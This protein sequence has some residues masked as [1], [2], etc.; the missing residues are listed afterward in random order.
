MGV[1]QSMMG[2]SRNWSA[3]DFLE[4]AFS[5]SPAAGLKVG[6]RIGSVWADLDRNTN[7]SMIDP[8]IHGV[9]IREDRTISDSTDPITGQDN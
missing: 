2:A 6:H 5:S 8:F 4:S 9:E 1:D 3:K 7:G